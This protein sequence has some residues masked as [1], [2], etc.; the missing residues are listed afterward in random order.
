[1]PANVETMA[2]VRDVPWHGL[3]TK[4]DHLMTA[5]EALE[6]AGLNWTVSKR[7][8]PQPNGTPHPH[9]QFT[10]RD[11]DLS[12]LGI[13][14][15]GYKIVQNDEAFAWGDSLVDSGAAKYETAGSLFNGQKVWLMMEL[16]EG[17]RVPGD[18]GEIKPYIQIS[19]GHDGNTTLRG[20]VTMVRTVCWNTWT[21]SIAGATRSFRI[22]HS[23]SIDGKLAA[24]REALGITFDYSLRFGE[25]AALLSRKTVTDKQADKA[26][27]DL[28]PIPGRAEKS[29]NIDATAYGKVL[30]L[31]Q[32]AP[33]LDP[34]RGTAWGV[35]QAV[36]EYVDHEVAYSGRRF[37]DEDVRFDSILYGGPAAEK[38]QK[39]LA[40]VSSRD[41]AR[42]R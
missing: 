17:I 37:D 39:A 13:V 20:D 35:L 26:F 23:G 33:N 8:I 25:V 22:K 5:S 42:S 30:D 7:E 32:S 16:P 27:R 36:G 9:R 19:N 18:E 24:A 14:G 12:V 4:V 38:K 31:Y 29:G 11:S 15:N 6:A 1:M 41:F 34:I 21:L 28:F 40:L 2:Y 10:V 3:G